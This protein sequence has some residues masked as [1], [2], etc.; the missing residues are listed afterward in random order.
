MSATITDQLKREIVFSLFDKTQNIGVSSGDSDRYYLAIGRSEEWTD[1]SIPPTPY[2]D[3]DEVLNFLSS[4]QSMKLLSEVSFVVPRYNWVSG[5]VYEEYDQQYGSNTEVSPVA[6][7]NSASVKNP[8]YVLTDDNNVF[9]CLS[10]GKTLSGSSKQSLFKPTDTSG[11]PQTLADDYVWAFLYNI[12]AREARQY[13]TSTYMPVERIIDE[14][15]GGPPD[16]ELSV[17]RLQ[18]R[19][20]QEASVSGQITSIAIEN[21]GT[22]YSSSSLVTISGTPNGDTTLTEAHA[23]VK[24]SEGV[25]TRVI[26]KEDST[27]TNFSLGENYKN[28]SVSISGGS[29]ADLRAIISADSGYGGDPRVTLNSS[30]LM[31]HAQTTGRENEDFLVNNDFRQIGVIKNPNRDSSNAPGWVGDKTA[32]SSTLS[33]LKKLYVN[34]SGLTTSNITGDQIVT[35]PSPLAQA[36]VDYYDEVDEV[37]YVHQTRDTGFSP[38]DTSEQTLTVTNSGTCQ[39]IPDPAGGPTL[40]YAEVDVYSGETIYIDNRLA[41]TRDADQTED[42][43]IVI[44]L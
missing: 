10:Q 21:A 33:A 42:I 26:M 43:K 41:V 12:G 29:G 32:T 36:I 28:A 22:G 34:G 4:V 23:Y 38:F 3:N 44:D 19:E 5:N 17:S 2:S 11:D 37:L 31:F 16:E 39:S 24:V 7:N 30:A 8:F 6:V 9:I 1:E 25:I 13:L 14:L 40:R 27:D 35:Q 20:I 18:Q 15:A